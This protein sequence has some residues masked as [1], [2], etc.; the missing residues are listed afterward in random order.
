MFLEDLAAD[1]AA[2]AFAAAVR[3]PDDPLEV[4]REAL[5]AALRL[6]AGVFFE[7]FEVLFLRV[8]SDTACARNRHASVRCCL[9]D[10]GGQKRSRY[11]AS[12][13]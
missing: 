13:L 6:A 9:G 10:P 4:F 8:L 7:V 3:A 2:D 1:F 5:F 12:F 11:G